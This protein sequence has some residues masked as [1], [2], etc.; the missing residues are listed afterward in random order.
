MNQRNIF[1]LFLL[2][3]V[4]LF[5]P[6]KLTASIPSYYFRSIGIGEG[7]SQSTVNVILQDRQ[8]FM[9]FG[10]KDGLNMYDGMMFRL[11]QKENSSLGNNFITALFEDKEGYIWVGT[12]AGVFVYDPYKEMFAPFDVRIDSSDSPICRAVTWIQADSKG[13]IWIAADYQ[14]LLCYDKKTNALENYSSQVS[15]TAANVTYFWFDGGI[16]WV[17]RYEDNLYYSQDDGRTFQ[18]FKDE[19]GEEPFRGAVIEAYAKGLRNCAYIGSSKGLLEINLSTRKVRRLLDEYVR[20]ICFHSD[21]EL[22]VGTEQGLYIYDIAEDSHVHLTIPDGDDRYAL[23]DNAIYSVFRDKEDGMWIGSYFGGINYYPHQYTYFEKYYPRDNLSYMGRRVR[24]FCGMDDGT[25]WI[26]TEDKGLFHFDS[27]K[28]VLTP[29]HHPLL[30]HNIH[31]LCLDGNYL[32]VGTFSGGLNR[33]DLRT[34]AV[35]HYAKGEESN[36]LNADNVFSICRTSTGDLWIGTTSGLLRY[37]RETDDFR[38]IPELENVFVYN[39]LEDSY[40]KLWLATYSDGAFCYDLTRGEW[41][42][43]KWNPSDS[44][45]LPYNKVIS[46]FEDSHR[47]LWF[48][49]QGAGICRFRPESG[50]FVRYDMSKGLPSNIVYKMLE[51]DSGL[52]W[53][54]TNKGLVAFHPETGIKHIY[55]TANGLLSNQFNYQSG[56]KD[57]NGLFYLGSINGFITF[58]PS[59]FKENTRISPVILTDFSLFNKRQ[60]IGEKGSPLARSITFTDTVELDADQNSFSLRAVVLSYQAPQ[61]NTVL[62]KLDG[63]DKEWYV[64]DGNDSRITYSNLPYGSYTLRVRG[65]NC[66]GVW[67]PQERLLHIRVLP[68]FYLSWV[69]YVVYLLLL[70]TSVTLGIRYLRR[71]NRRKHLQ[72]MERLHYEKERELYTAKIDFF[73]NVAHEIRTPLTLIKSPLENV[74][75][76]GHVDDNIKDDL[77]IMDLNTNRLLDLVNQLLDFRKTETRGFQLNFVECNLSELLQKIYVRFTPLARERKLE[78]SVNIVDGVC[79]AVD[80]EGFTKIVSNLLTNA[81][82]YAGT[83][84]RMELKVENDSLGLSVTNDGIVVPPNMR[85]EIFKPF[86]QY[87][88]ESASPVQGTGIG[89]A[90]SRSLAELHGGKLAMSDAPDCNCFVLTLP[91]QQMNTL[92]LSYKEDVPEEVDGEAVET[93]RNVSAETLRYTLMVVEDNVEMRKFL[94]RQLSSSYKVVEAANGTEALKLLQES[95]VNLIV[96]DVMM[97]EMDGLELCHTVKSELDYSHIPVILLTAKTTLQSKIDGLKAGADAYVEKPFSMEYLKVCIS[98]LLTS[99]EQL[100]AAFVH[101]PFVPTNSMAISKADE[102]FLKKLNDLVQENIQNPEFSLV[103]MAEKLC[104]SRSSLNRKIKG[105]LDITPNDYIRIERLKKAAQLLKD[106]SC[107]VNEVCYMVGFNTPSYFTKCFQKQFGVLPKDFLSH[108]NEAK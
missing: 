47:Q 89:L 27:R 65:A 107:K 78:L 20:D 29:F 32:W 46:I 54:T 98:N 13:R 72:A 30:S 68:P 33:I 105:I 19:K 97:P 52:L 69:A 77:E 7:L 73:T 53:V 96:S 35:K 108:C 106:G 94:L 67:N 82:K 40:G 51:D 49:T 84:I 88:E 56:Y 55:T 1:Y 60:M 14:G 50:D 86:I 48:T 24:E 75:A 93:G 70:I 87:R 91:L 37:N 95:I 99:R 12:D 90:L 10:T 104:M 79:A 102:E 2:L 26:G 81:I 64:V 83:Y 15:Q 71:R 58:N 80:R 59:S 31:G 43:Y 100:Q 57:K 61:S 8:G 34:Q 25:V 41:K 85:E 62:C 36:T 6:I 66:D 21:T 28:G 76:S 39:I 38:R 18:V 22:W 3:L 45:S 74:L 9:W 44:T 101:A 63:F 103:D 23:S 11:F 42:Q 17:G 16:M 4:V 92:T 5:L